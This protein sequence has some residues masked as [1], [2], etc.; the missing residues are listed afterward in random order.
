M[1]RMDEVAEVAAKFVRWF[2]RRVRESGGETYWAMSDGAP[3]WVRD[4]VRSAHGHML[5]DDY[6]YRAIVQCGDLISNVYGNLE[7]AHD[8]VDDLLDVYNNK[9]YEWLASHPMRAKYIEQYVEEYGLPTKRDF[10]M[11]P[12]L[13]G[14][15]RCE[16]GEVLNAVYE[17][18]E[19]YVESL[20]G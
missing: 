9:L 7:H 4:I 8:G 1:D 11:F 16:L 19:A 5:P 18:L 17:G 2:E 6:R 10:T 3:D 15:Q 13:Q 20:E 14:G 12:L